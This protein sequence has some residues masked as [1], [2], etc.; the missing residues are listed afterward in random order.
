MKQMS[1]E[2][3][4]ENA[5]ELT[6]EK[7]WATITAL[8][9][10]VDETT[11]NID[12]IGKHVDETTA[13]IDKMGR[14]VDKVSENVGGLNRSM[15]EL[16]ESL[17]TSRL[18][19]KFDEY[20]HHLVRAYT[21]MPLYNEKNETLSDIDLLLSNSDECMAVEIKRE[22]KTDDIDHHSRRMQLI[23]KYP[24]AEV[25]GKKIYSAIAGAVVPP[26]ARIYAYENGMYVLEMN[27]EH[28]SL[29]QP[30]DGFKAKVW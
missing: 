3:A 1:A 2:Q 25:K 13:T 16:I 6:F 4:L 18:W 12:K 11:A 30:P 24:P 8:G 20:G 19:E 5:R 29:L 21:R 10:R 15:G 28:V 9:Q 26:D 27:G 23:E 14:K 7:V 17:M 22:V